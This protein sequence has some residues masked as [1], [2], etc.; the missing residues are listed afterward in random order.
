MNKKADKIKTLLP[1]IVLPLVLLVCIS[2]WVG[3][4]AERYSYVYSDNGIWD[5]Q[6]FDFA[7]DNARL[8]GSVEVIPC[9]LLTP[10][11]FAE[12]YGEIV[13]GH[14]HETSDYATTRV[15]LLMPKDTYYTFS[16]IS[17]DF[18]DRIF[19]NDLWLHDVGMPADNID[20][21]VPNTARV[22]FTVRPNYID[23]YYVIEIIQ[24]TANMGVRGRAVYPQQWS[25]GG[26]DFFRTI[27]RADFTVN[28][29]LG[30]YIAL[31]LCFLLLFILLKSYRSNLYF[32]LFCLM[33]FLRTGV[34]SSARVFA[35]LVPWLPGMPSMRI[36]FVAMPV[37]A[38]LIMLIVYDLFPR[39]LHKYFLRG[40]IAVSAVFAVV[41]L[42]ANPFVIGFTI[43]MCQVFYF[44]CIVY[45]FAKFAIALRKQKLDNGQI[46]FLLGALL[47]LYG[48]VRDFT[49]YSFPQFPLPPFAGTNFTQVTMLAFAFCQATAMFIATIKKVEKAEDERL[50]LAAENAALDILFRSKTEFLEKVS[51]E[52]RTPLMVMGGY[53]QTTARHIDQNK[54]SDKT[55]FYLQTIFLESQRLSDLVTEMLKTSI[56]QCS[57]KTDMQTAV[58]DIIN[59][60]AAMCQ[61]ILDMN[62][63]RLVIDIE[64]DCPDVKANPDMIIQIFF[65]LVGNANRYMK[66]DT[67]HI[68]AKR[69]GATVLFAVRDNG[70]GI[71]PELLPTVFERGISGDDGTGLGLHICKETVEVHGG[72]ISAEN[73]ESG[74]AI[75]S[76]TL[77]IY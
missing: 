56:A 57:H 26:Y 58:A 20:D 61:P 51:H 55:R 35:V 3:L 69:E 24:Q 15:R 12:R 19:V 53:A 66:S 25:I 77:P 43:L 32:A 59:K 75:I 28:I 70:K 44:L 52:M 8:M 30:M 60:A 13:I 72:F 1:I 23:G 10:S 49:Y 41:I 46:I 67:I 6:G 65:N 18:A 50:R 68:S 9:A 37:A 11:E 62:K 74:G 45:T 27:L 76:F 48:T 64:I 21:I 39:V 47:F 63:N 29:V 36:E 71:S 73:M 4:A 42:F 33:W 17:T 22:T 31:A 2:L 5:L 40:V 54:L 7:N 16:R 34:T 14:A 38:I